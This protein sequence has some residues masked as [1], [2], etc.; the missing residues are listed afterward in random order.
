MNRE[1]L[2]DE[3]AEKLTDSVDMSDLIG[4]F[5]EKQYEYFESL[6]DEDLM[7]AAEQFGIELDDESKKEIQ[8]GWIPLPMIIME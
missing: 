8:T 5:Y 3:L 4:F 1:A 6:P 7:E 2:I